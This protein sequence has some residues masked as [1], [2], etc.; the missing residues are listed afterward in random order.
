MERLAHS[1]QLV[2]Q[3]K[4]LIQQKDAEVQ[5]KDAE[6][7]QKDAEVQQRDAQLKEER[8]KADAKFAKLKL[9]A[10]V[11]VTS[12][13]KQ[14]EALKREA[15]NQVSQDGS[16]HAGDLEHSERAQR[17]QE[18]AGGLEHSERAQRVQEEEERRELHESVTELT[19][20]LHESKESV[21]ELT[22]QLHE[23]RETEAVHALQ[24]RL[25]EQEETL[26]ARTQVVGMMEQELQNTE[27]QKRVMTEKFQQM[28]QELMCL[29]ESL[30]K[31]QKE[32]AHQ[33]NIFRDQL[34]ERDLACQRLQDELERE[35][36]SRVELESVKEDLDRERGAREEL[37]RVKEDLQRERGAQEELKRVKEELERERRGREELE[38]VREE[39]ERERR[40]R[41]EL[42]RVKADLESERGD[43]EE[44]ERVKEELERE[45]GAQEDLERVK[46]EL[47]RERGDRVEL[48]RERGAR[49]ELEREREELEREREELEREREELERVR[50]ARVE[51]ERERGARVE[52]ERAQGA[53]VELERVR[54]ELERERGARVE[55]ERVR[56]ELERERGGRVELE[57]VRE[58]LERERGGRVELERVR[59]ELE[60]ERG[61]RVEL[62]R[63]RGAR[64]ELE[65][66]RGARVELESVREELE[67]ERGGR[68]ELERVREELERERV[69]RIE[70]ERVR[71]ELEKVRRLMSHQDLGRSEWMTEEGVSQLSVPCESLQED[72][73]IID[74]KTKPRERIPGTAPYIPCA[75]EESADGKSE[76]VLRS[77]AEVQCPGPD[78]GP[79]GIAQALEAAAEKQLSI[80]MVDLSDAQEEIQSLKAQ[81][82]ERVESDTE[83]RADQTKVE[84][85]YST[86]EEAVRQATEQSKNLPV[87]AGDF[88]DKIQETS[89]TFIS[90]EKSSSEISQTELHVEKESR[91]MGSQTSYTIQH[92]GGAKLCE[93][94]K[95]VPEHEASDSKCPFLLSALGEEDRDNEEGDPKILSLKELVSELRGQVEALAIEKEALAIEKETLAVQ[96]QTLSHEQGHTEQLQMTQEDFTKTENPGMSDYESQNILTEQI[97]SLQNE[98]RSKDLKI[99][100]L[101]KDLDQLHFLLSEQEAISKLQED[102][103]REET[104]VTS[105]Q[106]RWSHSKEECLSEVLA[107][108]ECVAVSLQELLSQK[109]TE[110]ESLRV[111]LAEKDQ[112][113]A[114]VS[115]SLSEKMVLLNEEKHSMGK[116]IKSLKEQLSLAS[117]EQ[118]LR[119]DESVEVLRGKN[120]VVS[121]QLEEI[122]KD[123]SDL[124]EMLKSVQRE[125]EELQEQLQAQIHEHLQNQGMVESVQREREELQ[126]QLKTLRCNHMQNQE[127]LKS[128]QSER[129]ELQFKLEASRSDLQQHEMVKMQQ[130]KQEELQEQLQIMKEEQLHNLDTMNRREGERSDFQLDSLKGKALQEEGETGSKEKVELQYQLEHHRKENTQLK[131]KL[132][133]ALVNRKELKKKVSKLEKE[134]VKGT[135]EPERKSSLS[136]SDAEDKS[137]S[138]KAPE[139]DFAEVSFKQQLS[140]RESML[141]NVRRALEEKSATEER[142]QILIKEMTLE[143]QEKSSL[144]ESLSAKRI[145]SQSVIE[146]L[147][148]SSQNSERPFL[149][150][151]DPGDET[152][153][154]AELE[155]RVSN[156]EQ[157]KEHLQ[158][159]VQETLA[160]RRDTIKKAQEKDRHH[161]EQLKQ[162]KEDFN[163]LQE[164]YEE[165]Q[166]NQVLQEQIRECQQDK[167]RQTVSLC[168]SEESQQAG[169]PT[170]VSKELHAK[171]APSEH[172]AQD[173]SW[174]HDWVEFS[175]AEVEDMLFEGTPHPANMTLESYKIQQSHFQTQRAELELSAV[176]LEEELSLRSEEVLQLQEVVENLTKD[177][178]HEQEK[179]EESEARAT[180][181][182]IELENG[183]VELTRLHELDPQIKEMKEELNIKREEMEHLQLV[184]EERN[185][186]LENMKKSVLGK[187]N[188]I[189]ALKTQL[190]DQAKEH[191]KKLEVQLQEVQQKHEEDVGEAKSKQQLQRKL[192]AALISRKEALKESKMLKE[193]LANSRK[194]EE[195]MSNGLKAVGSSVTQLS[196]EKDKLLETLSSQKEEQDKLIAK[197]DKTLIENQNLEDSCES[198][199]LALEGVTQE[200]ESLVKKI[201]SLRNA[202]DSQSSEWQEKFSDLQKEYETLLQ[203]YENVSN[204][205]ER[206]QRAL[207]VVRLEKQEFFSKMKSVE[208]AKRE[209]EKQLEEAEQDVE[210]MKEKMRKFAKSKQQKILELEEDNERLKAELQ[211]SSGKKKS[212]LDSDQSVNAELK[213]KLEKVHSESQDLAAQLEAVKSEK[214]SV[215]QEAE[216]LRLQLQSIESKLQKSLKNGP[217]DLV[218]EGVMRTQEAV[219]VSA[220]SPKETEDQVGEDSSEQEEH[221]QKESDRKDECNKYIQQISQ[222]EA[223][224]EDL[225]KVI[226]TKEE[227]MQRIRVDFRVLKDEMTSESQVAALRDEVKNLRDERAE[228][229]IRNQKAWDEVMEVTKQKEALEAEKDEL[230]ERLMNQLAELNGSI[231]NYQQD[232]MDFQIRN[233]SLQCELQN[234]QLQLSQ[235]EEE[236]RQLERQKF[237][238]LSEVQKEYVEK[239]RSVHEGEK[240]R[241]TQAKE[242]QELLKEKQQEV[243]H[244][245]KDCIRYQ[246]TISGLE[247]AVKAL[248]FVQIESDKE[249]AA[250]SESIAKA[251]ED[252][253]KAQ[254]DLASLRVLLNDAQGEAA[255]VLAESLKLKEDLRAAGEDTA[256]KLRRKEE[257]L[258]RRLEHER[259][260]HLKEMKNMHEKLNSLQQENGQLGGSIGDLQSTLDRKTLEVKELQGNFNQN[261]AKLAAF[262]RS[263]CSLQDD[264]DRII[265]QSKK[266]GQKFTDAMQKKDDDIME[267]EET[268]TA[269]KE[270]LKLVTVRAE[271][272]RV[273]VTRLEMESQEL[274]R[275]VQTQAE[276]EL[277]MRESLSE[278]KAMLTSC[279]KEEQRLLCA[280]REE[281]RTW[282]QEAV[283]R[284]GQLQ[285]LE[286][287]LTPC[288]AE[289]EELRQA[290]KILE[291]E[292]QDGRLRSEQMHCDLQASKA[293]TEQ[294][295]REMEQKEQDVVRLLSARDEAVS[296]A[297]TELRELHAAESRS[298]E[299]RLGE[300]ELENRC[301]QEKGEA[302][303]GQFRSS[304]EEAD[305]SRTEFEALA[306]AMCS[307]QKERERVLSEYQQLEQRHL[308]AILTKD[309]LIQEAAT[310]SNE[311]REEQR[312]LRSRTDD[313]NAQNA[314][315]SAQLTR[316]RE[317]LKELISLKDSQLKQLLGE[318]LQEIERLQQ[319][320]SVL[321]EQLKQERDQK[322]VL[323]QELEE[324]RRKKQQMQ[325]EVDSL[326]LCVSRLQSEQETLEIRLA[327][328]EQEV[329]GLR[330]ELSQLHQEAAHVKEEASRL[331]AEAAQ[332]VRSMEEELDKKLRGLQ[333]DTGILRNETETA[334]ERVAELARDLMEAEQR[335]LHMSEENATLKAQLQAFGGSMRSLQ[336]SHD[337]MQ[338]ELQNLQEQNSSRAQE[339]Q[340]E[341]SALQRELS[342][343][344]AE[345]DALRDQVWQSGEEQQRMSAQLEEQSLRLQAQEE[346]ETK[347]TSELQSKVMGSL[348]GQLRKPSKEEERT[349]QSPDPRERMASDDPLCAELQNSGEAQSLRTLL[350]DAHTHLHQKELRI[351]QLSSK[352]SQIFEE[353]SSLSLQLRGSSQNLRDALSRYSSLQKQLQDLQ[354][355]GQEALLS[356]AA[357]GAPQER[358]DPQT[359]GSL[360]LRE[361]QQRFLE[362]KQEKIVA[363]QERRELERQ[364][365]EEREVRLRE[366]ERAQETE[367]RV[368]R[369]QSHDWSVSQD[370]DMSHELSLLIEPPD[371]S[372]K[373]RSSNLRRIL[374]HVF[375]SRTRTPLLATLYMLTIHVLLVLCFT[376]HL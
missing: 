301:L 45:R 205:T 316:Y 127:M 368:Q 232:A 41:E 251:M 363:E 147:A 320:H 55:L 66:E 128:V 343:A 214:A 146:G 297:S 6:V 336:D 50:G 213:V 219:I 211:P 197:V 113:V 303:M 69:A 236:K 64:V 245:Q 58:E 375:F 100:A 371:T 300:A 248:Q 139:Q 268:C 11:K 153:S 324:G 15:T 121:L 302:I 117:R 287:E 88:V 111:S 263:M 209:V 201:Q 339:E 178:Q 289:R 212:Q 191:S 258:E 32:R 266:W 120:E 342:T 226:S 132:Q 227:E 42:E 74:S 166:R 49:V 20:Q 334:E 265:D 187:E 140:E 206:M 95:G 250:F 360:Q 351:Q 62:E 115:H 242:L 233:D 190:E 143:L 350:R 277:R 26:R 40:D 119:V 290:L 124:Q 31:D 97:N 70:L 28:E 189:S 37:E 346:E 235:R 114:E 106:E 261:I 162:Q 337:H 102:H 294:L 145:E 240:S 333:H 105:L 83:E 255:R 179:C 149:I 367:A 172:N 75:A 354:P 180:V 244:L 344:A 222:L 260:K 192:Q 175:T 229:E 126:E 331:Q 254:T 93:G 174:G 270:E 310:E 156:L 87:F 217:T 376:G 148:A 243:R 267:K 79:E 165:L 112:Q 345:R 323:Q 348:Q 291:G 313:L 305:R 116:E 215:A 312:S 101:Q 164:K 108:N 225:E 373:A 199:K 356:D 374:R 332:R 338:E 176:R 308:S 38:S 220:S 136:G 186:A 335:L 123:K 54:E 130:T 181:L 18:H 155:N 16:E 341:V 279:L 285:A 72:H 309:V 193:E 170:Q 327:Q 357:P 183:L 247:R 76:Q 208:E 329:Q 47:E 347:V 77:C 292:V 90:Y 92:T 17:V 3:L 314:K 317:D 355:K 330:E 27:C 196:K 81:L 150:H 158:R 60:R 286:T 133:V 188:V 160:S 273:Q 361:L 8:E 369:L 89:S 353:K 163:L 98:S 154:K 103:L 125:R 141:E 68:V 109:T 256:S 278:E 134:L 293:L 295:H 177:L 271:E 48:E 358:K 204:E 51:L 65:I 53:R 283:D 22:R 252:T 276:S 36:G 362:V 231:G 24:R 67:R 161:R 84:R 318:K 221:L 167:E 202:Q 216:D 264:R 365:T 21:T 370:P 137:I 304:Q 159:K 144:I 315:L 91:K 234:L 104:H 239:L 284:L 110:V 96:L 275:T 288:K 152:D 29:R 34:A 107:A 5:Q 238:A 157:D 10:K 280:C 340:R 44:L 198:L 228:R 25:E 59:E 78:S 282:T 61:A 364:L 326:T 52:L 259:D 63:E 359:E 321:E 185:E 306:K 7:Q 325:Q 122:I 86:E 118:N 241:K 46:E 210:G 94:I 249:K 203:S 272:L 14:I 200:K 171:V 9:Q 311:L 80:L 138:Q 366:E 307:L 281:L 237:E 195:E 274:T 142:L 299:L 322:E 99:T 173:S 218:Q 82:T 223:C 43:R 349:V 246:E 328:E 372:G 129:E 253:M 168:Q 131:R 30:D 13:S 135:A 4:G 33:S 224:I 262:T 71:E 269:L 194:C 23:R 56:E 319:E 169:N 2:I 73:L 352:L 19:R 184:L 35:K 182:R 12:L 257:D 57:R 296:V 151:S 85:E 230:E 298:L 39:L 207:E 1:E